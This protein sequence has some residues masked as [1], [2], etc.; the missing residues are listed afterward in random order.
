MKQLV[1]LIKT[2]KKIHL[3]KIIEEERNKLIK[4]PTN[5]INLY[6]NNFNNKK[7]FSKVFQIPNPH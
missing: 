7:N 5:K 3:A 2:L 4:A 1:K 6:N